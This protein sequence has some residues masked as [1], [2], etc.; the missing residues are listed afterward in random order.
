[1][2][3]VAVFFG[4]VSCEHDVS[5]ITGVMTVNAIDKTKY[6]PIPIYVTKDGE[7]KT[8]EKLKDL[9]IY[10]TNGYKNFKTVTLLSGDNSL[11]QV[12]KSKIKKIGEIY[13]A[14]NCMHGGWGEEGGLY[15]ALKN[16]NI[17]CTSSSLFPSSLAMDKEFTKFALSGIG[18]KF[19]PCV[20]LDRGNYYLRK[21]TALKLIEKRLE[22]P[23]IIK[24]ANLGSSIG[25]KVAKDK[26]ELEKGLN[27]AFI[28]DKK[29]IIESALHSP[30]EINCAVY[31]R[32]GELIVSDLEEPIKDTELLTFEDKYLSPKQKVFPAEVDEEL[33]EEIKNISATVYRKLG[34]SGVIRIDFLL[35]GNEI[36]VNEINA[37]PGSLAYYLFCKDTEEFSSMVTDIIEE[38]VDEWKDLSQN[39]KTFD[40]KVLNLSSSKIG[41]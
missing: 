36:F 17:P 41:K 15:C 18:V 7:W 1:M 8:D 14:V 28:F 4:G 30:R 24:P 23:V 37:V 27:L 6:N 26:T 25:I 40:S 29:V 3:N 12:Q 34:F 21:E 33:G 38:S 11:Y 2:K 35:N 16:S 13:S 5:V 9:S 20:K 31:K 10:K 22:Y 32:G 39:K 19:L